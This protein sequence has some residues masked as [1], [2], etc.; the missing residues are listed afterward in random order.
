MSQIFSIAALLTGSGLLLLAGGLHGLLLPLRGAAEGFS[1]TSLGLLGTGWAIGYVAGCILTPTIVSRVGHIRTF[2]VFCSLAGI[3]VLLNL[4][5][6]HPA[7][8]IPL[9]AVSGFCFA[10]AAMVVESWLNERATPET[11]GRIF[12]FYTMINLAAT[13]VGQMLLTLGSPSGY[14]FFVIG[15]IVYSLALLPTA[16]STVAAPVP[17]LHSRLDIKMLWH[18]SPVAV[19]SVFLIGIS[20]SAFGTLGA[21]YGRQIGLSVSSIATMMSVA[22]LAGAVI[23]VPIGLL[24]D[25]M[26]RRIVL[27]GIGA[28]ACAI[29]AVLAIGGGLPQLAVIAL[30]AAFGGMIYSMYP[31]IV[32][33]AND[34]TPAGEFLKTSGG[35]LLLFGAGSIVGPVIAAAMMTLTT[36]QGLFAVTSGAHAS[37]IAFAL[38]R[39]TQRK[40]IAPED[41]EDFVAM[42][43]GV[44]F[45][46]PETLAMDPRVEDSEVEAEHEEYDPDWEP[47]NDDGE[48]KTPAPSN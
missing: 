28:A 24:S 42:P 18:N 22:L 46:T 23:Q 36:P 5:I 4:L 16:L 21:V 1:D 11:R 43:S 2:G 33:H 19:I 41:R 34:H 20:N 29:G 8:W 3:A 9:R 27:V 47:K 35:L 40:A 26:D 37:L 32:A 6:L 39:M 14:L 12:G 7:A 13:T 17:L 30:V 10:G 48:L 38:F 45:S 25:R 31:V 44:R 15:S